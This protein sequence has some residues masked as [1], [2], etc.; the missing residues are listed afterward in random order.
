MNTIGTQLKLTFFGESHGRV[1]GLVI[2]GLPSG[3]II[4]EKLLRQELL[5]R[6]QPGSESSPRQEKDDFEFLSGYQNNRT[7][8]AALT[9]VIPNTDQR[10]N[11]YPETLII[12][13][14]GHADYPAFVKYQG[15]ADVA[16]GGIFSGRLTALWVVAGVI[17]GQILG[18]KNIRVIS[19]IMQIGA[20]KDPAFDIYNVNNKLLKTMENSAFPV[21]LPENEQKMR[22]EIQKAKSI[23]DS[24]GGI[25]EVV[26]FG[27]DA[28]LGD[29][30]FQSV[31]SQISQAIFSIPAIKG[32]AFGS[33]FSLAEMSGFEANDPY[34]MKAGRVVTTTNH[35]GGILGGMTTG[36]P[37]QYSVVIKP[38]P[39]ISILQKSVD[40]KKMVDAD[41]EIRGRHDPCIVPKAIH[42][43]RAATQ[44]VVLDI[45]RQRHDW[46]WFSL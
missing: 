4:D 2:D 34:Q 29:P 15:Y 16:G 45:L 10:S 40:L 9:V 22:A 44:F 3:L 13:R 12:P 26:V 7:T 46:D 17:C 35:N 14:P 37:L 36:M 33:G 31:E 18:G 5:K 41:L 1:I 25:G 43:I 21:I 32:I 39:S 27:L 19:H 20:I 6:R 11:D 38:T 23:G 28:G 8:G 24:L 42:V 30:L